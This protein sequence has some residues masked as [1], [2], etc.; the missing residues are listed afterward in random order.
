MNTQTKL[1]A[2]FMLIHNDKGCLDIR[3]Q[4]LPILDLNPEFLLDRVVNIHASPQIRASCS[5]SKVGFESYG[6]SGVSDRV[7]LSHSSSNAV[8]HSLGS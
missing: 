7:Y 8:D 6:H 5:V 4:N 2:V 1:I 3:Y